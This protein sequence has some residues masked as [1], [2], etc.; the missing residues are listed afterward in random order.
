MDSLKQSDFAE[1]N[2]RVKPKPQ[3][4]DKFV[5]K[6]QI[7]MATVQEHDPEFEQLKQKGK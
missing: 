6:N 1:K 2:I 7:S 5:M 4:T 3:F